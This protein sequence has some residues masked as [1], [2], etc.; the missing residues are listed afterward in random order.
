[1][2]NFKIVIQHRESLYLAVL[3]ACISNSLVTP[4]VS[5][6]VCMYRAV[7][8]L[9]NVMAF[10]N[11]HKCY[12]PMA[13]NVL[14]NN[15]SGLQIQHIQN[16]IITNNLSASEKIFIL[17]VYIYII[18]IS[19]TLS[20]SLSLSLASDCIG[21]PFAYIESLIRTYNYGRLAFLSQSAKIQRGQTSKKIS[22][23]SSFSQLRDTHK[24]LPTYSCMRGNNF[25]LDI[26][27][28]TR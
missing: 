8:E 28:D 16:K 25:Q 4:S 21:L 18:Y 27:N 2:K 1:M 3:V 24:Y 14:M 11:N 19:L 6:Y 17:G 23:L 9:G 20:L 15:A 12:G 10:I 26:I 13:S 22:H 7:L 5:M